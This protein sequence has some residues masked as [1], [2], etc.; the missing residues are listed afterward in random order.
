MKVINI[1][2][3]S[4]HLIFLIT[5]FL[6]FHLPPFQFSL[7]NFPLSFISSF[8]FLFS[9]SF[10]FIFHLTPLYSELQ[11]KFSL[12]KQ[13]YYFTQSFLLLLFSH[14]VMSNSFW[15]PCTVQPIRF[16][17]PWDSSGKNTGVGCHS[18]LQGIFP[19]QGKPCLLHWQAGSLPLSHQGSLSLTLPTST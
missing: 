5:S 3:T 6:H 17:C 19:T 14:Q 4:A 1:F 16:L 18:L 8:F 7:F 9:P 12:G 13:T 15:I 10:P 2:L 11:Q